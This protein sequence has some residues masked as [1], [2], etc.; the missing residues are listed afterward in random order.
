M[1][2][3]RRIL[4][5]AVGLSPQ[6]VTETLYALVTTQN[7]IPNEIHLITTRE[8][9]DRAF[10]TLLGDDPEQRYFYRLCEACNLDADTIRFDRNTMH[11]ISDA[12]QQ[13]LDDIRNVTDNESAADNI[14]DVVRKLSADPN[15]IM[16]ASIAGGRKTMGFYVGYAMSLFAREQDRL[17]HV[18][19]TPP[20]ESHPQFFFPPT[21]ARVLYDKND[22]P[23]NTDTAEIT[24]A[25]IPFVRLRGHLDAAL[26]SEGAS[27]LETVH[28][29]QRSVEPAQLVLDRQARQIKC[30]DQIIQLSPTLFAFYAWFAERV[31]TGY[32]GLHW[33]RENGSEFLHQYGQ[34]VGIH[35]AAYEDAERSLC[36]GTDRSFF[37]TKISKLK[38]LL[39]NALG[40]GPAKPYLISRI[41]NISGSSYILKGLLLAA[42]QVRFEQIR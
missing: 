37:D 9:A 36:K 32:P 24:L 10:L 26:L 42:D 31:L 22:R 28:R 13:P 14:I 16:H 18:L 20:F 17:S 6:I 41:G 38:G 1:S 12:Q 33:S 29:A 21:Q 2:E 4:L 35:S 5:C 19:V 8:G 25:D 40:K 30:G 7:F 23:M 11:L 27:Y 15:S 3:P 34:I 39:E